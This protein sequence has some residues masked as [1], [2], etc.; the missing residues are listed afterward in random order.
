M[1][2]ARTPRR[3]RVWTLAIG[4]LLTGCFSLPEYPRDW[5]PLQRL[6]D[7]DCPSIAGDFENQPAAKNGG[8]WTDP[9][10][11][12][13]LVSFFFPQAERNAVEH[14]SFQ[15]GA[16]DIAITLHLHNGDTVDQAFKREPTCK[17]SMLIIP[18]PG[19]TAVDPIAL[20]AVT[21]HES[22][23]LGIAT[24]GSLVLEPRHFGGGI[25]VVLPFAVVEHGWARYKPFAQSDA[26]AN[27]EH[28]HG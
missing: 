2:A 6:G 1:T 5:P 20:S 25:A 3:S 19:G 17:D 15:T 9:S 7:G 16:S 24:D 4:T 11:S 27:N 12:G 10:V 28:D 26:P 23:A 14:V 21:N 18:R 22:Y 13:E 8:L